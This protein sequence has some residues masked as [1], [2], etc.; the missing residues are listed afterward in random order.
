MGHC[1]VQFRSSS[2]IYLILE[3]QR[4]CGGRRET[5]VAI[6]GAQESQRPYFIE[7]AFLL[8]SVGEGQLRVFQYRV[9]FPST[10]HIF[11]QCLDNP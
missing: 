8:R 10:F 6:V 5:A 4:T 7:L 3:H 1:R 2:H 9:E 11:A